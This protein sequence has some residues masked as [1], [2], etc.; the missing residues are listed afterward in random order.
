M[1]DRRNWHRC[2]D[3]VGILITIYVRET[4]TSERVCVGVRNGMLNVELPGSYKK[5]K[6]RKLGQ[7]CV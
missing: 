3:G 2:A 7:L 5:K 1:L 4:R 6:C